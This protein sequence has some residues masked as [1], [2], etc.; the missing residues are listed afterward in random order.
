MSAIGETSEVGFI[1]NGID[2][3]QGIESEALRDIAR[4]VELASSIVAKNLSLAD[5]RANVCI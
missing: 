4:S 5:R 2:I 1:L 3:L